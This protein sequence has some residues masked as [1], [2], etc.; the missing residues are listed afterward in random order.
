MTTM[1]PSIP[2]S[3]TAPQAPAEPA[4]AITERPT[5]QSEQPLRLRV[6]RPTRGLVVLQAH[7]TLDASGEPR[8]AELLRQHVARTSATVVLDLS[9][10]T[11]LDTAGAVAML[12]A[13][14]RA[15]MDDIRLRVISSPAVDR[16]L[17]LIEVPDRFT[18]VASVEEGLNALPLSAVRTEGSGS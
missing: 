13:A 17:R 6:L 5:R 8:F 9:G 12:E 2:N 4:V 3:A 7:G 15:R 18:Y 1:D 14:A 10:V 11:F 16:L